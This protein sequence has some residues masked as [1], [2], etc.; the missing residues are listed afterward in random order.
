MHILKTGHLKGFDFVHF[1]EYETQVKVTSQ[2]HVI[3]GQQCDCKLP[4][5]NQSPQEPL[6]SSKVFTGCCTEDMTADELRQFFCQYGEVV[7]VFNPMLFRA[8]A[9]VPFV[10]DQVAQSLCEEDMTIKGIGIHISKVELLSGS[11]RQQWK[12]WW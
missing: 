3:D 10:D 1:T 11:N 2:Q 9:F 12:M 6:G 8:F 7:D 5:S 4:N